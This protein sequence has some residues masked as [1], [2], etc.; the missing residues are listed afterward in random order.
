MWSRLD[1]ASE[2]FQTGQ[3]V[4]PSETQT[5]RG[6]C[7]VWDVLEKWN[8]LLAAKI[9]KVLGLG[10]FYGGL[11]F[12]S[13]LIS[14]L[15]RKH[16]HSGK[17]SNINAA[18]TSKTQIKI[19]DKWVK[20]LHWRLLVETH[21]R[22]IITPSCQSWLGQGITG[23]PASGSWIHVSVGRGDHVPDATKF[24]QWPLQGKGHGPRPGRVCWWRLC[25]WWEG[26]AHGG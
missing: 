17:A 25:E 2:H 16:L 7:M 8:W 10:H 19:S 21:S 23:L 5:L 13:L 18:K 4:F 24:S 11:R 20:V 3:L 6:P 22:G 26:R 14:H 12:P 15:T 1:S 9:Y